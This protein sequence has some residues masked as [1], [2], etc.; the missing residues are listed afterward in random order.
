MTRKEYNGWTNYETWLV[1]LWQDNDEGSQSYWRDHAEERVKVDGRTD[2]I[3]SLADIM[4]EEYEN[5]AS[6][7]V[8][9]A[10]VFADLI[11]A[12]LSEVDWFEIAQHWI[13]EAADAL[14]LEDCPIED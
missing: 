9:N 14:S 2:G 5:R 8:G 1:K 7:M 6:D 10:G 4:K 12:A 11:T 13:E 3:T